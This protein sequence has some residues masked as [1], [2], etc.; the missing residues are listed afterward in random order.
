M[1]AW[2]GETPNSREGSKGYTGGPLTREYTVLHEPDLDAAVALAEVTADI[3]YLGR[4]RKSIAWRSLGFDNWLFTV[5]YGAA[6]NNEGGLSP[7][8][9]NFR[10]TGTQAHITQSY[11]TLYRVAIGDVIA[12]GVN[13]TVDG[14]N[15]LRLAPVGDGY[16]PGGAEVGQHLVIT[17]GAGWTPGSYEIVSVV[18]GL[19]GYFTLATGPAAAGAT[20]GIWHLSGSAPDLKGA[21]GVD[22]DSILGCDAVVPSGEFSLMANRTSFTHADYRGLKSLVGKV[23]DREWKGYPAGTLMYLGV[24]PSGSDGTL[25]NGQAVNWWC[26][27]HQFRQEDHQAGVVIGDI[28]LPSVPAF[29]FVHCMYAPKVP[30]GTNVLAPQPIGAYVERVHRGYFDPNVLGIP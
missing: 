14:A 2:I 7:D 13:M 3:S 20:G 26:L 9:F 17:G 4:E 23:T 15:P 25:Q 5:T 29:S 22:K 21:I 11:E 12:G 6:G 30:A 8:A 19:G 24:E 1:A 28:T 10:I 27:A 16:D 18:S